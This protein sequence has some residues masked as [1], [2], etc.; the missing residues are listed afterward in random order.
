[1]EEY[2]THF[3]RKVKSRST[4]IFVVDA[5]EIYSTFQAQIIDHCIANQLKLVI[6]INKIDVLDID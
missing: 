4:V 6:V 5:C 2:Y 1:M 3:F